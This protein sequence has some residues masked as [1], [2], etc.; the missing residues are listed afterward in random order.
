MKTVV[1]DI[2]EQLPTQHTQPS[3]TKQFFQSTYENIETRCFT[4]IHKVQR[5]CA[6]FPCS[7]YYIPCLC[8][9]I[10][11]AIWAVIAVIIIGSLK[12]GE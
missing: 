12:P 9:L 3:K 8:T 4:V 1:Q 6:P 11:I 5:F 10:V 2:H 7:K